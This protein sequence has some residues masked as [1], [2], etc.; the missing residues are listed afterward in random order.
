MTNLANGNSLYSN[1][2]KRNKTEE[3]EEHTNTQKR[4][5]VIEVL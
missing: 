3:K 2:Y 4:N 5:I 1:V